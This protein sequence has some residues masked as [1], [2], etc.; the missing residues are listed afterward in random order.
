ML[1]SVSKKYRTRSF[2]FF[3][4]F[5]V[6]NITQKNSNNWK[7]HCFGHYRFVENFDSKVYVRK[8]IF[9][10]MDQSERGF[11]FEFM[12]KL[13]LKKKKKKRKKKNEYW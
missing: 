9:W 2:R 4:K 1:Y 10:T 7:W 8:Q 13:K 3:E 6:V 12:K 5:F 11:G